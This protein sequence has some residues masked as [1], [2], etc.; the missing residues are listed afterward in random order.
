MQEVFKK[1]WET[2]KV[3]ETMRNVNTRHREASIPDIVAR[4]LC[5]APFI[6]V[7]HNHHL[8]QGWETDEKFLITEKILM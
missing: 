3:S 6:N 5:L 7:A 8:K 2:S 1:T 4:K